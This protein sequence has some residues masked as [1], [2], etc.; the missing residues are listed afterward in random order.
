MTENCPPS[1]FRWRNHGAT[2]RYMTN[3]MFA[4]A[5]IAVAAPAT[6]HSLKD[7]EKNLEAREKFFQAVD[8]PAPD[9]AFTDADGH[10][11]TLADYRGQV[12]VLAFFYASCPDECP[13]HFERLAEV[14]ALLG[15]AGLNTR[16]R[17]VGITTDP[18]NDTADVLH[19]F[20]SAHGLDAATSTFL[21]SRPERPTATRNLAKRYGHKFVKTGDRLQ[22]HGVVTH[23]IDRDG[24]WVANFHGLRF[25]PINLVIVINALLNDSPDRHDHGGGLWDRFRRLF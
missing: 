14:Q 1:G 2:M 19:Q 6:A 20:G 7:V 8:K 5:L 15:Q 12:V 21:T 25:E 22:I 9:F 18:E 16:V 17:V 24:R 11:V 23:V 3:L 13:L 4:A 10:T